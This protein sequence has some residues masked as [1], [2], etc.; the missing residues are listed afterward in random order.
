ML[1]SL[2][3]HSCLVRHI[4]CLNFLHLVPSYN[5]WGHLSMYQLSILCDRG[6]GNRVF[7]KD[8]CVLFLSVSRRRVLFLLFRSALG[9]MGWI[10]SVAFASFLWSPARRLFFRA[11]R[12]PL[13]RRK[14]MFRSSSLGLFRTKILDSS[15]FQTWTF[16]LERRNDKSIPNQF[17]TVFKT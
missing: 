8:R 4:I 13:L 2:S 3:F 7:F 6:E 11:K 1:L 15:L 9:V 5:Q 16:V 10:G 14:K 17:Q 12:G